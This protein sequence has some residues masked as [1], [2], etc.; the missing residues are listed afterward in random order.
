MFEQAFKGTVLP[1]AH[2]GEMGNTEAMSSLALANAY[3]ENGRD[4]E[5]IRVKG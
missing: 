4:N 5:D 3:S 1:D 2:H